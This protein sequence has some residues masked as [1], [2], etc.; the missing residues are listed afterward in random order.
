MKIKKFES[1]LNESDY[2][3]L[4]DGDT[5]VS[6]YK[7]DGYWYEGKVIDGEEPYGW[8]G[9]NYMSYLKPE[10]IASYLNSDYGGNWMVLEEE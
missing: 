1:F 7:E 10:D 5:T 9:K 8:G 4:S 2:I 3:E 6:L